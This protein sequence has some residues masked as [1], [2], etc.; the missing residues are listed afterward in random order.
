MRK[1]RHTVQDDSLQAWQEWMSHPPEALRVSGRIPPTSRHGRRPTKAGY[2]LVVLGSLILAF[3]LGI[4]VL[5][6]LTPVQRVDAPGILTVAGMPAVAGV[7][8]NPRP[9]GK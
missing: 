3:A 9:A 8:R 1:Q 7:Q 4:V 6:F 5:S 2:V